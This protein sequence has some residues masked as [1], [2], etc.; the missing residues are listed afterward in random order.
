[1][2]VKQKVKARLAQSIVNMLADE[3]ELTVGEGAEILMVCNNMIKE[4]VFKA[5]NVEESNLI[6]VS[7]KHLNR[8]DI[9]IVGSLN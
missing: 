7:L 2:A 4:N 5:M 9:K 3:K 1:M 6:S 8:S